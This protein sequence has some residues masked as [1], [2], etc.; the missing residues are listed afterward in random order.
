M[1]ISQEQQE[2]FAS[3]RRQRF[4]DKVCLKLRSSIPERADEYSS[5]E[6]RV[7]V[8]K[9]HIRA[10]RY[11]FSREKELFQFIG[12]SLLT[13]LG[14]DEREA[15]KVILENKNYLPVEK[16]EALY[17]AVREQARLGYEPP[18]IDS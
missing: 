10:G 2:T 4:H 18:G 5:K 8:K 1:R 17:F 14:F 12:L 11:G 13:G 3:I 7:F 16:M 15:V 9:A 6:L